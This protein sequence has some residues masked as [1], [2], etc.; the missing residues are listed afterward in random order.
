MIPTNL[1]EWLKPPRRFHIN[2]RHR[3][4]GKAR[5]DI[6]RR[7]KTQQDWDTLWKEPANPFPFTWGSGWKQCIEYKVEDFAAEVGFLVDVLGLSVNALGAEYAQFTSPDSAFYLGVAVARPDERSTPPEALRIQFMIAN[8]PAA[9]GEL[10][11]RGIVFE[12]ALQPVY[13]GAVLLTACFRTPH[14]ICIDLWG[15]APREASRSQASPGE[16]IP[17]PAHLETPS[18]SSEFPAPAQEDDRAET[19]VDWENA[20]EQEEY[21]SPENDAPPGSAVH[22]SGLFSAARIGEAVSSLL[23]LPFQPNNDDTLFS[24]WMPVA[25]QNDEEETP[26][27]G[28]ADPVDQVKL[29]S[30]S[31]S[32]PAEASEGTGLPDETR[33]GQT[34]DRGGLDAPHNAPPL[35]P[36]SNDLPIQSPPRQSWASQ[37]RSQLERPPVP[38]ARTPS[39]G[40]RTANSSEEKKPPIQ[41]APAP[42]TPPPP[43]DGPYVPYN[44][45]RWRAPA[46]E[47]PAE[48]PA[49]SRPAASHL[50][51][52]VTP[53][54]VKNA[55]P[56][57]RPSSEPPAQRPA[58]RTPLN[59]P[60]SR[61]HQNS[62]PAVPPQVSYE[63]EEEPL[64]DVRQKEKDGNEEKS[65][66]GGSQGGL[67]EPH[68]EDELIYED[69]EIG[70][71]EE[72]PRYE[73][74]VPSAN[75]T[76][77]K[78]GAAP[79]VG[80]KVTAP[81]ASQ[82][83]EARP[84]AN[85]IPRSRQPD[86]P[87][88]KSSHA[89][90]YMPRV[91]PTRRD[92]SGS[93]HTP[94]TV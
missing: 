23:H 75:R 43:P 28:A 74:I 87:A 7:V 17:L 88:S 83:P 92:D 2:P 14:G 73:N 68:Y 20:T 78:N 58:P 38:P 33:Q 48:Q 89:R 71:E 81:H 30:W 9:F 76:P 29:F 90:P 10:Q 55:P 69:L 61:P 54:A 39:N 27:N 86:Y 15:E 35:F 79:A 82:P 31:T 50:S 66:G 59:H 32:I 93:G 52:K 19:A 26:E 5:L 3:A 34:G 16:V 47:P 25:S 51:L 18:A 70:E 60:G 4:Y 6:A 53:S 41:A 42:Q 62:L 72:Q 36:T 65:F 49:S 84:A 40:A 12:G 24:N 57:R 21:P 1:M 80:L 77:E 67:A 13:E 44:P 22:L 91:R 94:P 8:L 64:E 45:N 56:A 85:P 46:Q 63:S 37:R 11:R